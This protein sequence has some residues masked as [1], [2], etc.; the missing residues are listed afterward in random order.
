MLLQSTYALVDLYWVQKLGT[1]EVAALS[2]SLQAFFIILAL[3]QMMAV[4]AQA[5][6]SQSYGSGQLTL[7]RN[8]F[9]SFLL[10]ST[11][12]GL[13]AAATA[14]LCAEPYVRFFAPDPSEFELGS[15]KHEDAEAVIEQGLVYFQINAITFC[16]Q[17]VIIVIGNAFRGSGDF[18]TPVKL[19]ITAVVINLI[20]DPLLIFGLA[21]LPEMGLA[22]AAWATVL[23]QVFVLIGYT[24][25][26]IRPPR[27][28]RGIRLGTP[29]ISRDFLV[30][31]V[32]K[33]LPVGIQFSLL[34]I[35]LGLILYAM[36][37]WGADWTATAGA[38]FRVLQQ[39]LLP[40]VALGHA[41]AA[42]AGQSF[43]SG[44]IKRVRQT[45]W[46]ATRWMLVYGVIA[47]LI[48]FFAG[49]DLGRIFASDS[50]GLDLAQLY[51]WWSAPTVLAFSLSFVP[52]SV[53]QA[54]SR[55]GLPLIAA[56]ARI[57]ALTILIL[58]VIP[59][60]GLGPRWVFGAASATTFIE[61]GLGT[62]FMWIHLKKLDRQ[63]ATADGETTS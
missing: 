23:A 58:G 56:L 51:Y 20:L 54:L 62:W 43:G 27:D 12:L 1:A 60:F 42:I 37:P 4:T 53:L 63:F 24:F 2:I 33:G 49:R 13:A 52:S 48:L 5:R 61:G 6:I 16:T 8:Y 7:A 32:Q 9:S 22:G 15:M 25:I 50:D 36:K 28:E 41:S 44:S 59:L 14:Y 47:T 39:T 34:P 29:I 19:M 10:M 26:L 21:G 45:S 35:F 31:L 30:H 18:L 38:G 40:M 55:P 3:A 57:I 17:L 11:L 46:T